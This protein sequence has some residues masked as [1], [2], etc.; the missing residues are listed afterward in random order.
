MPNA[1]QVNIH[2]GFWTITDS[3]TPQLPPRPII[4]RADN[5]DIYTLHIDGRVEADW[6]E[7]MKL[8]DRFLTGDY[9]PSEVTTFALC[10]ALWLAKNAR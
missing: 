1:V 8:K 7:I 9:P 3:S 4:I 10:A 5:R 6:L 2:S